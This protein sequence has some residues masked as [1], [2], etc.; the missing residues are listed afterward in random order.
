MD[1]S[2]NKSFAKL[3]LTSWLLKRKE[4]KK[5]AKD[6]ETKAPKRSSKV[7]QSQDDSGVEYSKRTEMH[8][9]SSKPII[10]EPN[11]IRRERSAS[12]V[13]EEKIKMALHVYFSE[14]RQN[15]NAHSPQTPP[16]LRT[17]TSNNLTKAFDIICD[18][19]HASETFY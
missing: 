10:T 5:K 14:E 16:L 13:E 17:I 12:G 3:P 1:T 9:T 19:S 2:K 6:K 15:T 8:K 4:K 18:S 7:R 11:G